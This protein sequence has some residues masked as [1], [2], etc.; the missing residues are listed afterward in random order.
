M[1]DIEICQSVEY[2]KGSSKGELPW[3]IVRLVKPARRFPYS[4][5]GHGPVVGA[6]RRDRLSEALGALDVGLDAD[7]IAAL[8][9]AL[10]AGAARGDRYAPQQMVMLDSERV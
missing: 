2:V 4:A 8:E 7:D 3:N 6:R 9:T 5:L 1:T 10:P